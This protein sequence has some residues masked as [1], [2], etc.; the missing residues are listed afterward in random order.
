MHQ[1]H[2]LMTQAFALWEARRTAEAILIFHQL[3]AQNEPEALY[4]LAD[5]KWRGGVV[6]RDLG[7]ARLLYGQSGERGHVRG[8]NY[9]TNLLGNGIAGPRDWPTALQRLRREARRDP[10]RG[11]MIALIDKMKLTPEGDPKSLPEPRR[12]SASPE[13][14]LFPK[15]LSA[16]EC[17]Y[18]KLAAEPNYEPSFVFDSKGQP[19]PDTIRTSDGSTIQWLHEDPVIHALNRRLAAASGTE[20]DQGEALQILRYQPGQQYRPHLDFLRVGEENKRV[21]TALVYLNAD[22]KGGET[23]F[24]KT[25]LNVKGDK[26]D[27]IVFRNL[28]PKRRPDPMSEHA[29]LPVTIGTKFLASRWIREARWVP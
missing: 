15:L 26:G 7:Q 9:F 21:L 29:G 28:D 11:R 27:A 13:V 3:A 16:A 20:A 10:S 1:R 8:A 19:V 22:Y 5:L 18:L 23:C 17:D 14:T 12:L 6:E 2:P 24:V 4:T 25:G